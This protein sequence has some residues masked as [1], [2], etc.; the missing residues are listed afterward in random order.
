MK[1]KKILFIGAYGIENSGDDL[2]MIVMMQQLQQMY[3][4]ESFSFHALT[5]H[6]NKW[7]E[8]KFNIVQHKNLEYQSRQEA[9]NKWFR[10]LNFEDDR[11]IFN[12]IL[13]LIESCD[14]LIIGAGNFI[15]DISIDI[16]KGPIPL[17]WWYIHLAKLT[18]TKVMLYGFSTAPL[19]N[20]YAK[21]LTKEIMR[22]SDFISVRDK[23]SKKYLQTLGVTQKIVS[24]PDPTLGTTFTKKYTFLTK[25]DQI[26][27]L[28]NSSK[29]LI[30]LGLR[31][32]SFP[33]ESKIFDTIIKFI[34]TH[35]EYRYIFVPQSTYKEDDDRQLAQT[36]ATK[37]NTNISFHI[38]KKRY[39]PQEL[40]S[41]YAL[42]DLTLSIRL[43]SCVF[44]HIAN[45]PAIAINYLPKVAGYMKEMKTTKQLLQI[46]DVKPNKLHNIITKTLNKKEKIKK[47]IH[48]VVTKKN[49]KVKKYSQAAYELLEKKI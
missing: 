23:A 34:N 2:P 22:Q 49:K 44:S 18:N 40:I 28:V 45:T 5:R 47:Q 39:T 36:L 7:E 33:Q 38:I 11:T 42:C 46:K 20:N 4:K 16:F 9:A 27:L 1:T 25:K 31:Q 15:I 21:L 14:L 12:E 48:K 26:F 43:H 6:P 30:A 35:S 41:I 13:S 8:K 17:I 37:I 10:G 3:P 32:F 24:L 29:P 19:Q